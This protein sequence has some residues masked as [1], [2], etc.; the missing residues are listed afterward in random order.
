M[1]VWPINHTLCSDTVRYAN[2]VFI[3]LHLVHAYI[4]KL[5]SAVC[6][7]AILVCTWIVGVESVNYTTYFWN[8]Q[9]LR[10][11]LCLRAFSIVI[12]E[13]SLQLIS[14]FFFLAFFCLIYKLYKSDLWITF[15]DM[16]T[17]LILQDISYCLVYRNVLYRKI[18]FNCL[19]IL[20][21]T[22]CWLMNCMSWMSFKLCNIFQTCSQD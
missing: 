20:L 4:Q 3:G 16:W 18:N 7:L 6:Y 14:I 15:S 11:Y 10:Q 5:M 9:K 17:V 21:A 12:Y 1:Q 8:V 13:S 19:H 2:I 22:F